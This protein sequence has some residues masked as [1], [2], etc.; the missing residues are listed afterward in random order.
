MRYRFTTIGGWDS[1]KGFATH[2]EC[3]LTMIPWF[4]ILNANNILKKGFGNRLTNFWKTFVVQP[5]L[6]WNPSETPVREEVECSTERNITKIWYFKIRYF[7]C[8]WS[9]LQQL[10][11]LLVSMWLFFILFSQSNEQKKTGSDYS[12]ENIL[13]WLHNEICLFMW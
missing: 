8:S 5:V 2:I 1:F 6:G 4:N 12:L 10:V 13:V 11:G 9:G 7:S 3:W